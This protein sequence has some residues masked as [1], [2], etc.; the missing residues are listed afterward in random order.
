[1]VAKDGHSLAWRKLAVNG[2]CV[3]K[4]LTIR[5]GSAIIVLDLTRDCAR[6]L[7]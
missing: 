5:L 2:T 3:N 6:P 1:M 7:T 4:K